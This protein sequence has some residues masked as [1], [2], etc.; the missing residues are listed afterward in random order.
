MTGQ[1]RRHMRDAGDSRLQP[2]RAHALHTQTYL[3]V[4]ILQ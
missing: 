4:R 1:V 2:Y 3:P